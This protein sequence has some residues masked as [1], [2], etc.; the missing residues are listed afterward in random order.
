MSFLLLILFIGIFGQAFCFM[1]AMRANIIYQ[2]RMEAF[3]AGINENTAGTFD[4][5]MWKLTKWTFKSFY[6]EAKNQSPGA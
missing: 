2:V 4:E 5:M 3:R 1:M 6:P